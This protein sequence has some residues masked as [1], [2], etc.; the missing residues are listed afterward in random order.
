M[1]PE[2]KVLGQPMTSE[3]RSMTQIWPKCD[4]AD[5]VTSGQARA[6]IFKIRTFLTV[7][8]IICFA[9][10]LRTIFWGVGL[11]LKKNDKT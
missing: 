2:F 9:F 5:N 7:L 1:T 6:A 8:R 11:K 10:P 4:F 3:V